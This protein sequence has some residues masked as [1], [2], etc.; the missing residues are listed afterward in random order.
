MS[1]RRRPAPRDPGGGVSAPGRHSGVRRGAAQVDTLAEAAGTRWRLMVCPGAYGPRRPEEQAGLRRGDVDLDNFRVRR[2]MTR[3][4]THPVPDPPYAESGEDPAEHRKRRRTRAVVGLPDGLHPLAWTTKNPRVSDLGFHM[5][6]GR[7]GGR[8]EQVR[9]GRAALI[10]PSGPVRPPAYEVPFPSHTLPRGEGPEDDQTVNR[11]CALV[12]S[13]THT[14][15]SGSSAPSAIAAA[16][17]WSTPGAAVMV[18][19][20]ASTVSSV[21]AVVAVSGCR[22]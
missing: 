2:R 12:A 15:A 5:A 4:S 17:T 8:A 16:E 11:A 18:S 3:G 6:R 19:N 7:H 14:T 20:Q 10:R 13:T 21:A 9:P 22:R 1:A